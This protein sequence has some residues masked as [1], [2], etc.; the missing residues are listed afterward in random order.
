[1]MVRMFMVILGVWAVV[2]LG[3]CSAVR[4]VGF[5]GLMKAEVAVPPGGKET[6]VENF[7]FLTFGNPGIRKTF[8]TRAVVGEVLA[9]YRGEFAKRGWEETEVS[10]K[11]GIPKYEPDNAA[12]GQEDYQFR[13]VSKCGEW[14]YAREQMELVLQDSRL[15]RREQRDLLVV[16]VSLI[17]HY[18]WDVPGTAVAKATTTVLGYPWGIAL[19]MPW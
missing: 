11:R 8:E 12:S 15:A 4:G 10:R 2:V 5:E 17:G 3:G 18:A 13:R 16:Q 19:S 6:K 7:P 1:M 14:A 9:F